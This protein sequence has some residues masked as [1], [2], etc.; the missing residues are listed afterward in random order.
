M[1]LQ[2]M[3]IILHEKTLLKIIYCL[4]FGNLQEKSDNIFNLFITTSYNFE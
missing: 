2:H 4:M 3:D 1:L